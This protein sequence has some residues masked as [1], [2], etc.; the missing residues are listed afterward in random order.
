MACVV[1]VFLE[2]SVEKGFVVQ[3]FKES[4]AMYVVEIMF[5]GFIPT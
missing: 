5:L 3:P 2:A 4:N 1:H